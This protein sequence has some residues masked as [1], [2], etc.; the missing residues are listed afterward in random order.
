MPA[1]DSDLTDPAP[2]VVAATM[3]RAVE[4]AN[5]RC[6][7]GKMEANAGDYRSFAAKQLPAAPEGVA[8]WLAERGRVEGYPHDVRATLLGVAWWTDPLLSKRVRV[9]GRRIEPANER[10]ENRFGPPGEQWPALCYVDPDHVIL[11]KLSGRKRELIAVCECG[12]VGSPA[13]LGWMGGECGPCHDHREEHGS[14]L[15]NVPVVLRTE[16]RV[17][18]VA[19]SPSGRRVVAVIREPRGRLDVAGKVCFFDR[20]T[21]KLRNEQ[22]HDF[23]LGIADTPFAARG[24]V[25]VAD[26]YSVCCAWDLETGHLTDEAHSRNLSFLAL[27]PDGRTL[28]GVGEGDIWE[29]KVEGD[30]WAQSL[31]GSAGDHEGA[32]AFSPDGKTL[33]AGTAGGQVDLFDWNSGQLLLPHLPRHVD[34]Q[35]IEALAFS[36]DGALLAAGSGSVSEMEI[37][38]TSDPMLEICHVYLF[39]VTRTA[40]LTRIDVAG[41][42]HAVAF[43][44]DGQMLLYGGADGLVHV[45]EVASRKERAVLAGHVGSVQCLAFSPDGLTLASGSGDG[46][47]RFWPWPQVLARPSSRGKR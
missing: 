28:A 2:D 36:P 4:T 23:F 39:D 29:R 12:A 46:A 24:K 38:W 44:P 35:R 14:P 43:S 3:L 7:V 45:V 15:G 27:A 9:V 6:R 22:D 34:D 10:A 30:D 18:H 5:K 13:E 16:G 37:A 42:V 33:A 19:F 32:L 40:L 25:G 47:V 17:A 31:P 26:G 21:G 11:R 41:E 1:F 20:A 8:L